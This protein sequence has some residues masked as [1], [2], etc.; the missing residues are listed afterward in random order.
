ML[1]KASAKVFQKALND[2]GAK[3]KLKVDGKPGKKTIGAL[4]SFQEKQRIELSDQIDTTLDALDL[5]YKLVVVPRG[6]KVKAEVKKKPVSKHKTLPKKKLPKGIHMPT[7]VEV[8]GVS[9][10]KR[11]YK[12]ASKMFEYFVTHY[13]VSGRT[14]K[15]AIAVLRYLSRKG[16]M[17]MV[18]DE[19]GIIY[20]P[21]GFNIFKHW[22]AH[23]GTSH[24][25]GKSSL[26]SVGAGMEICCWGRNSK[27]GPYRSSKGEANIIKGKYQT[28]TDAQ[29]S[30]YINFLLY[31]K[32][33][34]PHFN[35]DNLVGH[36]EIRTAAGKH[37]HKQ[38][39]GASLSMT[40]PKF[41]SLIKRKWSKIK[42]DN[43]L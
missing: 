7:I 41:R 22:G 26:N 35:L 18:M 8:A 36:D 21:K 37:G 32:Y 23:A 42:K 34:N 25:K 10:K 14:R 13:T 24:W 20:I 5:D 1:D 30:E 12:T 31:C 43:G 33:M 27:K 28:Y 3:P 6:R 38:D 29:E 17:C 11:F 4:I 15:S 40:M 16:L 39:P 2:N 19:D 9:F